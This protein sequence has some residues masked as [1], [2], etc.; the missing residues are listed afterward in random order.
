MRVART[1]SARGRRCG[2]GDRRLESARELAGV[3]RRQV[4]PTARLRRALERGDVLFRDVETDNVEDETPALRACGPHD[5]ARVATAGLEPVGDEDHGGARRRRGKRLFH[6]GSERR[7]ALR[8]QPVDRA[9]QGGAIE[10]RE[11]QHGLDVGAVALVPV[12]VSDE[13]RRRA[14]GQAV[15]ELAEHPPRADDLGLAADLPHIE[16][17]T[18]KTR[19]NGAGAGVGAAPAG[20]ARDPNSASPVATA[21]EILIA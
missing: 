5:T 7:L 18:S 8:R 16:P 10:R 12:A 4:E 21:V 3:G 13:G 17:E 2:A 11:R 15:A 6:R 20:G 14:V 9:P 1:T 19:T